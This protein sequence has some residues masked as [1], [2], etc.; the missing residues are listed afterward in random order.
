MIDDEEEHEDDA[1]DFFDEY[2]DFE[3]NNTKIIKNCS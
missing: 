2:M 3:M 1:D